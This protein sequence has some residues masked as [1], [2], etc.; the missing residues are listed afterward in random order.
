[1]VATPW[2]N[3]TEASQCIDRWIEDENDAPNAG[4]GQIELPNTADSGNDGDD[5]GELETVTVPT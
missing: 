1:L 2:K 4:E 3:D 5:G